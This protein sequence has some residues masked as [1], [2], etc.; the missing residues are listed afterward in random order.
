[1][2][3]QNQNLT[4]MWDDRLK[5]RTINGKPVIWAFFD[6]RPLP[7]IIALSLATVAC[8]N[9]PHVHLQVVYLEDVEKF[10]PHV[11]P[12]FRYLTGN[13]KG[14]YFRSRILGIVSLVLM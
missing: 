1:M 14:D 9:E 5:I 3:I 10:I 7:A 2:T 13:H 6:R 11:H 8:H 4:F 12:A